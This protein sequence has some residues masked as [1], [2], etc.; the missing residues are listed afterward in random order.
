MRG[1]Q[2][3]L[4]TLSIITMRRKLSLSDYLSVCLSDGLVIYNSNN[5]LKYIRLFWMLFLP[6][7]SQ[8]K[9]MTSRIRIRPRIFFSKFIYSNRIIIAYSSLHRS[10]V[11]QLTR[12]KSCELVYTYRRD[13]K[14]P[15]GHWDWGPSHITLVHIFEFIKGI[16]IT[17]NMIGW[18]ENDHLIFWRMEK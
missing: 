2:L 8:V 5:K 18:S 16:E 6:K 17:Q 3:S 1:D 7:S 9:I 12:S 4:G 15:L 10:F 14:S 13:L 11:T